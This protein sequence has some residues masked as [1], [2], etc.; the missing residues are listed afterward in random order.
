MY[1]DYI[2]E[3]K[4]IYGDGL[5]NDPEFEYPITLNT[6]AGIPDDALILLYLEGN[7]P[8]HPKGTLTFR[9]GSVDGNLISQFNFEA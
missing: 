5:E 2:Y 9:Q 6:F 4:F 1:D 7:Y 8:P 3:N